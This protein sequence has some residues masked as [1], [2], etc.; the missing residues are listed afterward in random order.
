MVSIFRKIM[1]ISAFFIALFIFLAGIYIGFLLDDYRVEDAD[2][3][4]S[5]TQLDTESFVTER[6]FFDTFGVKNCDL[7]TQRMVLL[8]EE[9]GEIGRT[10]T[11]YNNKRISEGTV[12][13]QLKRKYFLLE[14]RAYT[15]RRQMYELCPE[16][17]SNIILF[18]YNTKNN[19]VSLNQGYALDVLVEKHP[20]FTVLS[21]DREF[22][23]SALQS[24]VGYYNI[25]L[26]PSMIINFDK[27]FEGYIPTETIL[28]HLMN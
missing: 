18:F 6:D 28:Q 3:I 10:L 1:L 15:L 8:G 12:F 21:F 4:I 16:S 24:L 17:K 5:D 13:D 11:R 20:Q 26:A 2:T 27:K 19:Q 22:N 23:E 9:L 7:L 25:T 14:I